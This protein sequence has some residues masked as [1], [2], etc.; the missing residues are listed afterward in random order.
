VEP[1]V[2]ISEAGKGVGGAPAVRVKLFNSD[3]EVVVK[4]VKAMLSKLNE[5]FAPGDAVKR[6]M[7][8]GQEEDATV[9]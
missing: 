8:S 1:A 5:R 6:A 2:I 9:R 3:T 7:L 4:D